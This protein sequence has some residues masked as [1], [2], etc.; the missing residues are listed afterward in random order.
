MSAT[1]GAGMLV[2][3]APALAAVQAGTGAA[4]SRRAQV[5][6][7]VNNVGYEPRGPKRIVIGGESGSGPLAFDVV[8]TSSGAVVHRGQAT[9]VGAVERWAQDA[10]PAVPK[11]Y[12]AGDLSALATEGQYVVVVGSRAGTAD[13]VSYPFLIQADIYARKTLSPI[14]HYFKGS[15]S[16][17][18]YAKRDSHLPIGKGGTEFVD[19]HGGWY[20]AAGDFGIHFGQA[21]PHAQQFL[22]STQV[23]LLA[24]VL[25][26]AYGQLQRRRDGQLAVASAWMLDEA[27]YGAD[28]L[29]RMHPKEGSF[30]SSIAQPELDK[31]TP[32]G[33]YEPYNVRYLEAEQGRPVLVSFRLGGGSAVAALAAASTYKVSGEYDNRRYLTTAV[34]AFRYLQQHN[35]TL[36]RGTPDNILDEAET[37]VAATELYKATGERQYAAVARTM[38]GKLMG[39]LGSWHQYHN[40]WR[41]GADDRPFFNATSEGLPAV[42]L[43][44]YLDIADPAERAQAVTVLRQAM[45]F[46]LQ[47][48]GEGANPFGYAREFVQDVKG[49]RYTNFFYPHDVTPSTQSGGWWQGENARIASLATAARL[50]SLQSMIAGDAADDFTRQ[51]EQY[52]TDQLNWICGLNPYASCMLNGVGLNN[53]EYYDA[54]GTWQFLPQA[55]G[56]NN[57]IAGVTASGRGIGYE[58]HY[59]S[60]GFQAVPDSWRHMEQSLPQSTWFLYAAAIGPT[61]R[62]ADRAPHNHARA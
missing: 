15:R 5:R 26:A 30:Y 60:G 29:V 54:D 57:G 1:A 21:F 39:R 22:T 12:W 56:I 37:L 23:P 53:P 19:V 16:S 47:I 10:S 42:Y 18:Q 51:L 20:D 27:M 50:V 17:G 25:F 49:K 59:R 14:L 7:F 6:I 55:G 44:N 8:D 52:A 3:G 58:P 11:V 36:N 40:Y 34:E 35:R 9:F 2:G 45:Q 31:P 41:A 13:S 24:W 46:A 61:G 43:A 4:E 33:E 38:A 32:D 28:F 62:A 48:T